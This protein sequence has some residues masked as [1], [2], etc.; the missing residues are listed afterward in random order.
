M[1]APAETARRDAFA[2]LFTDDPPA[3]V[4]VVIVGAGFSGVTSLIHLLRARPG[5]RVAVLEQTLRRAPGIAYGACRATNLLNVAAGRMGAFPD[6]PLG[7]WSWLERR[8]PGRYRV[9][10]FVP[11]ALF[12]EYLV[13]ALLAEL[14]GPSRVAF[15]QDAVEVLHRESQGIAMSTRRGRRIAAA[16]VLLAVGLPAAHP[17][18]LQAGRVA[19]PGCVVDPWHAGVLD[20]VGSDDSIVI[21]GTGLTALDVFISLQDRGHSGRITFVSR[22]GRFPLPHADGG[23]RL[24]ASIDTSGYAAGARPALR[25]ARCLAGEAAR[26]GLPW[27]SA[28]DALRVHAPSI[29]G[30]WTSEERA[31]FLKRLRPFWEIHRHRAPHLTLDRVSAAVASGRAGLVRGTIE[32]V[33]AVSPEGPVRISIRTP[34]GQAVE[35]SAAWIIN[36]IGPTLKVGDSNSSLIKSLLASGTAA[37]DPASLGLSADDNGRLRR[38]DGTVDDRLFLIGALRRGELWE[39]TAVPE[40]RVQAASVAS[41]MAARLAE[42]TPAL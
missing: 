41:A 36:C 10:D 37:T 16:A 19:T 7:F 9:E 13:D 40:L 5:I 38:R 25:L 2:S 12:G 4:D 3:S 24:V 33:A 23:G 21:V 22:N 6:D 20:R 39:S 42:E 1:T 27:Q 14:G 11:R 8:D 26:V 15:V 28:V 18:W 32:Q 31:R 34:S 29:W 35:C 30:E 17:P